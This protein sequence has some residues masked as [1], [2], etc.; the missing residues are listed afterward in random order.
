MS[1]VSQQISRCAR[2]CA[3]HPHK[4]LQQWGLIRS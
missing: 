1:S 4:R 3:R 2:E